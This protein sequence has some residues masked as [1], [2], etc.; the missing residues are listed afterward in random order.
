ML[1]WKQEIQ[2]IG[3]R[4]KELS[5]RT[6][7][8]LRGFGLIAGAGAKTERLGAKTRELIAL[9]V[10]VTTR[11]DGCIAF[12]AA[13]AVKLGVSDDEIA[14]ALGVAINLNA[15]AAMTYSTHVLD[16]IDALK[17]A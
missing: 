2:D 4:L 16:A 13:E 15:G 12:H 11:C 17:Q 6:P 7:D 5:T 9:A 10:A 1:E 8:T 14:E 3:S